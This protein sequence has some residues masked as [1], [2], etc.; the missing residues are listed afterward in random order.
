MS[1]FQPL[2]LRYASGNGGEALIG[3]G[4]DAAPSGPDAPL[5]R[6]L[7]EWIEGSACQPALAAANVVSLQGR[8]VLEALA[9]ER[10]A[11]MGGHASQ[12][13]TAPVTRLL[14]L[15]EPLAEGGGW[16][17]S[18]LDP[19]ADWAPMA[20]G[21]FKPD[22]PRWD[23]ERGRPR[24][25]EH[26]IGTPA[27]LFWLRVPAVVALLV[28][29][30]FGVALPPEVASDADGSAGAFWRWWAVTLALPLLV[31]EGAKKAAAL[32]SAGVPAV[33]G[34]GIWNPSAR[35]ELLPELAAVPLEGRAVWV[36]F[37]G[38]DRPDPA[39]PRA[40]RRLG[41]LLERA[42]ASVLVGTC[43]GPQKGA[44]DALAAGVS[45]VAL[46]AA[47]RPLGP[48]PALAHLRRADRTVPGRLSGA[49]GSEDLA[50]GLVVVKASMGCGKT[51]EAKDLM[52][53]FLAEGTPILSPTHRTAL[54]AANAEALGIPW[55]AMP[56]TDERLQ[57]SGQCWDS[58]RPSSALQIRPDG[59]DGADGRG[60]VLLADEVAQGVEHLLFGTGTAVA[61]HRPETM[62][63]FAALA[64][65]ARLTLAMDAQ[66]SEPV[67]ALL[68][69]LTGRRAFL[70]SSSYQPMAGRPV[71]VPQGLT[72]RSAAEQGRARV[73]ELA[74][75]G[76][77]AFVITTAQQDHAKG[78]ARNLARLV[79]RHQPSA[80]VLVVD[81]E[82]PEAAE[83]LGND[84]NGT[85]AAFDWIICSPS[86]TSGLSIDAPG[87][88]AEVVVIG[89]GGRLPCEHLAQAAA[90]VRDPACPVR[91]YAP[92]VAPQ[93]RIGSGDT[94]PEAL[95]RH[96][97]R[98]EAHLL[99]DL[100][101]PA[102]WDPASMNESP[103]LRC[104]LELAAHRNRQAGAYAV[105]VAA[106]LEAEGWSVQS[107]AEVPA[108]ELVAQA[109]A[110][111][112]EIATAA[113][114]A[115][116]AAVI[117]AD[118][119]TPTEAAALEQRRRLTPSERAA[120]Q[121]HRIARRW[122]LGTSPPTA[123]L[124]EADRDGLAGRL[125]FG[126]MLQ[127]TE[128][129][130]RATAHDR[131]RAQELAPN[132]KG[133][134][135][136]LVRELLA[137]KLAAADALGLPQ[138]LRETEWIPSDDPRFLALQ[139]LATAHASSLRANLGLSPGK[140]SSGTLRALLRLTGHRLE[141][142]RE[143]FGGGFRRWAYRVIPE[144]LPDGICREQLEQAW[145]EQLADPS[146]GGHFSPLT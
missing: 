135:P 43:P 48:A 118:P 95:F 31:T 22:A 85:A 6:H 46:A 71:T 69:A 141:A 87:L 127:T 20:W 129:R 81:S 77:G 23:A 125:R 35:G 139:A 24:K 55:A 115:A 52:A 99:A 111:L 88:F 61:S 14:G 40:A 56:G 96:L 134:A 36:L 73:L 47:L 145:A 112:E 19:L 65:R 103:W 10:L 67:L 109:G 58:F 123:A 12:Y 37:D 44:D 39:E 78:S 45:W 42:G 82:A 102:G 18:G 146:G 97:A 119:I 75:A 113:T 110:D 33:A 54:G 27:R 64:S 126:W 122:G 100:M 137:H 38:S 68:E 120:L 16:W 11:Q 138:W 2:Q 130:K 28:A 3:S 8:D 107:T 104:W 83:Q 143:R 60:P 13:A 128:G 140:R 116:D 15:L 74:K 144:P 26:P 51:T 72:A 101:A 121:R 66:L 21:C 4:W 92:S 133:W 86:I 136:D 124:L 142:R 34:P 132:G 62:A 9:G 114:A 59:W 91:I 84:P 106:L 76:R 41:R 98:S 29:D 30:R 32:L 105:T 17:C 90:R 70:L 49:L 117:A 1:H 50:Q 5:P 7:A 57:G 93:L 108:P 89:A 79:Q 94:T 25:Y 53:P 131:K 80:R 63:T